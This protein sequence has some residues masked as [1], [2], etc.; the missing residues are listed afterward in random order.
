MVPREDIRRAMGHRIICGFDGT[1]IGSELKEIVREVKPLGLILFA[2]N[3]ESPAQVSE[4]C[5]ELKA[6]Q[7]K[8]PLLIC[9][10]QEGGRVARIRAPATEWPPM[11]H[12]GLY[13]DLDLTFTIAEAMGRE[14]RAMNIDINLAP[15]LD[16]D[17]NPNNPVIGDRAFGQQP[18]V[19]A[20]MGRSFFKGLN[21][22]TIGACGKH[23]PGHGDTS[24]DSHLDL[25]YIDH[26]LPRLKSVE[27]IPFQK[28]VE[29]GLD[30]IMTA[31]VVVRALDEQKPATLSEAA[32]NILRK[33]FH[34]SG[35]VLSDDIEMKALADR[36]TPNQI[37]Q[38]GHDAGIDVFLACRQPEVIL[39]LYRSLVIA[40]E[41]Q[42]MILHDDIL[43]AE[44]RALYWKQRWYRAAKI[45]PKNLAIIGCEAH[46]ALLQKIL[47]MT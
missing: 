15:V 22:A 18:E 37:A 2:R 35:V 10:D 17:T 25:P 45:T 16:V 5:L 26:D 11:R 31:H 12:L 23:F 39:E 24:I 36:Y 21:A 29:S 28:C 33:K 6:L 13:G 41:N 4:L 7:P 47:L 32:I 30:A 27:W 8:D 43:A 14:L 34:F 40:S 38:L 42:T 20:N 3:V 44:K 1:M 9:V 46:A 19:V